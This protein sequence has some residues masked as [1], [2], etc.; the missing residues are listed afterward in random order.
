MTQTSDV[1]VAGQ[2]QPP[3]R[4]WAWILTFVLTA[5]VL[6]GAGTVIGIYAAQHPRTDVRGIA[7]DYLDA[8]AD[9]DQAAADALS[10]RGARLGEPTLGADAF[11]AATHITDAQIDDFDVRYG[12][13]EATA[14]VSFVLADERVTDTVELV[15]DSADQWVVR[16]GLR[17]GIDVYTSGPGVVGFA[18]MPAAFTPDEGYV[19]A[20]AGAYEVVSMN[21]FYEVREPAEFLVSSRGA[22]Y[23][24]DVEWVQPSPEFAGEVDRLVAEWYEECAAHTDLDALRA[25]GI[26]ARAGDVGAFIGSPGSE[27]PTALGLTAR[28]DVVDAPRTAHAPDDDT[29]LPL[30]RAGAFAITFHGR[31]EAGKAIEVDGGTVG[32]MDADVE[33]TPTTDGLIL[34]VYPY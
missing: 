33:V 18:G 12:R 30:E 1:T 23:L 20:Y 10:G 6:G 11:A 22:N 26:D 31:D 8:V 32:A 19:W 24:T 27:I 28:V 16:S 29:W 7:Q 9:G 5:V 21:E 3:P 13:G 25:C 14:R 4:T 2:G 34:Q 17:Y 15:A